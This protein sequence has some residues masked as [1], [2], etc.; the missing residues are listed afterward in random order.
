MEPIAVARRGLIEFSSE[1]QQCTERRLDS[2]A[3]ER[4]VVRA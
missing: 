4:I 1:H 2:V 3:R